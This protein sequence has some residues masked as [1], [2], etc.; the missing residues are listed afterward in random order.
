MGNL[1]NEGRI[2]YNLMYRSGRRGWQGAC[3]VNIRSPNRMRFMSE[4]NALS[5]HSLRSV[6]RPAPPL[7][8]EDSLRRCIALTRFQPFA[9]LPVLD[10]GFLKGIVPQ[11][12]LLLALQME[13]GA[14]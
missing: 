2:L 1:Q 7:A 6:L 12:S 9:T 8:P 4:T 11:S 5:Q 14:E 10:N 3:R 13:A